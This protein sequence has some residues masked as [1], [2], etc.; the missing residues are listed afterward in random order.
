MMASKRFLERYDSND[1]G[2]NVSDKAFFLSVP[3]AVL[4]A[5]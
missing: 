1:R 2:V 5:E 4:S 3:L